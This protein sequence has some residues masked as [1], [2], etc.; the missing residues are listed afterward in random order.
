MASPGVLSAALA[1][2]RRRTIWGLHHLKGRV[3]I[4]TIIT[5]VLVLT[6]INH[7]LNNNFAGSECL[8]YQ[9]EP[10]EKMKA[11]TRGIAHVC[12]PLC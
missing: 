7:I 9:D 1:P 6:L 12:A 10:G 3:I 4:Y 8:S 2:I 11:E 5:F